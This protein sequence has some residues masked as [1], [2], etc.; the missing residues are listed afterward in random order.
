MHL[1]KIRSSDLDAFHALFCEVAAEGR[2]STRPGAPPKALIASALQ[3][4]ERTG[5]A[6]YV[7]E[8]EG[9]LIATAEA[10][11]DTYCRPEGDPLTGIL[12]MQVLAAWRRQ[13]LG[14]RL[15]AVVI[16]HCREQ[17]FGGIELSVLKSN[18][19]AIALYLKHGFVWREDLPPCRLPDGRADQAQRMRLDLPRDATASRA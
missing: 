8:R 13:G 11:P 3:R 12:G 16:E 7:I 1:R 4:A 9:R 15:L 19:A 6:V 2:F 17:G 18:Q 10:Y 14:Q 5:W